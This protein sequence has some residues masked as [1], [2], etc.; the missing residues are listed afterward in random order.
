MSSKRPSL[1]WNAVET[2]LLDMDGTLLDLHFDN[3]FWQQHLPACWA[4]K[5]GLELKAAHAALAPRFRELEGT[6]SWYCLDF[7]TQELGLDV[8]ALKDDVQ[9]KIS[10]R[11]HADF[12]LEQLTAMGKSCVL[13]TN[14]HHAVLDYK[15]ARTGIGKYFQ[16]MYTA[17]GY[18][19]PKEEP[20]FWQALERQLNFDR[21]RTLLIDDNLH[22][23]QTARTYGIG[24]LL[25]ITRP[26][27]S[28][29]PREIEDFPAVDDF[30]ELFDG[31]SV[32]RTAEGEI[33]HPVSQA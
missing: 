30:R 6:L 18:G 17:H 15:L 29:P 7:W 5:Q 2:V 13:V 21:D 28:L 31:L 26:D 23:L 12:L 22:V 25:T 14:A 8:L 32:E 11:P 27:S 10:M 1:D 19:Q 9:H 3:Y 33:G 16:A 4:R 20:G 24:H